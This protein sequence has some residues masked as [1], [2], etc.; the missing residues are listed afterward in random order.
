MIV[1]VPRRMLPVVVCTGL[2][3]IVLMVRTFSTGSW[4]KLPLEKIGLGDIK[5]DED[6]TIITPGGKQNHDE[7]AGGMQSV[8]DEGQP[9][10]AMGKTP[11]T[12][13]GGKAK[14][15]GS[16][17]TK[18]LIVPKTKKE[19]TSWIDQNFP[20]GGGLNTSMYI[21]DDPTAPLH[22][23][24]NKGN[25]VMIYLTY[26]IDNYDNLADVNI[27]IHAHQYAW[28]NDELLDS[29]SAQMV[30]RLSAE[31]VQREGYVNLRC[32]WYPG[33]PDWMH[34]GTTELDVNKQE[35]RMLA[36]SWSE[37]F[38][39]DSI[40]TVLAQPCC[41]QFALSRERIRAL[42]KARYVFY[43]DWLLRTPLQNHISGRVWEYVW[44]YLF[45]GQNVMCPKEHICYCDG[46]GV[47]FG[48]EQEYNSFYD[49]IHE[50]NHHQ[51]RLK[52]IEESAKKIKEMEEKGE[53]DEITSLEVPKP[54]EAEELQQKIN[55][56]GG[57]IQKE[58]EKAFERGTH[59][60]NR[61]KE[62]GR[63]WKEGDGF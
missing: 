53:L 58:K 17:Y 62:A 32:H 28:H 37:L 19:D 56:L 16:T 40:P 49:K 13:P 20:P 57:W 61:A 41:A 63:P 21:A 10:V 14:P 50:K 46:F 42:P 8:E 7:D 35:E 9:E 51:E 52:V 18:M 59:A 47:C 12:F 38:P 39:M 36:Q 34:P 44:H 26:I 15:P 60:E 27:F 48:G 43:R 6:V 2:V 29:D 31:R 3:F 55:E 33:C 11:E 45:T 4:Q 30:S 23:P 1:S 22:P 54:G 24:K 25:E 5:I